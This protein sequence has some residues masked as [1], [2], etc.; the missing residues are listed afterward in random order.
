MKYKDSKNGCIT[1]AREKHV[2]GANQYLGDYSI[3]DKK[4]GRVVIN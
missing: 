3:T 1:L 2:G 4:G